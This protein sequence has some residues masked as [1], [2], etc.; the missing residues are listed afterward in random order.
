[1]F[2]D[3]IDVEARTLKRI[4]IA[5]MQEPMFAGMSGIM[6]MGETSIVDDMPTAATNG[7]DEVYGRKFIAGLRDKEVGF[8]IMH[9]NEHKARRHLFVWRKLMEID[10]QLAN[11][12]MDYT[13]NLS[14]VALDPGEKYISMPRDEKGNP[15]G[16]YDLRFK[17]MDTVSIFRILQQEKAADPDGFDKKH[18]GEGGGLDEHDWE[19]AK[20][21]TP[22][23]AKALEKEVDTA[24][25]QGR[26][27]KNRMPGATEGGM[28]QLINELLEPEIDWK[29][30]LAEF[31]KS[32][33]SERDV[34]TWKKPNRR[35]LSAD[36]YMP[37]MIG[38]RVGSIVVGVDM[39][40]STTGPLR[41]AFLTEVKA[42]VEQVRPDI[43][44]L[45]YWDTQVAGHEQY[46]DSNLDTLLEKTKPKGGGGTDPDC[47][48]Q[49][50]EEKR[51]EPEC[52]VIL[53]DGEVPNWG[54][55]WNAPVLWVIKNDRHKITAANGKTIHIKG[56][57]HG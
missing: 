1:M 42:S 53:T 24:L 57:A 18:G 48:R 16:V 56:N 52:I 13:I 44:H 4:K 17:E 12:A 47:I 43:L 7:R 50:L 20:A 35:Y 39:S 21:L 29:A 9:E 23:Q 49:Y 26:M 40:G 22:E 54:H 33:C 38:E 8:V 3:N 55:N 19:R 27:A 5:L 36:M 32:T 2:E 34:S 51:I 46:D 41:N 15:I 45:I 37:S 14:L 11:I 25:R 6:M 10:P 31:I 30:E 28:D